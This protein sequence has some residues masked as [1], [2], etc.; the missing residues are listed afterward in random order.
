MKQDEKS[1]K[2][3]LHNMDNK[4]KGILEET[5]KIKK[6]FDFDK[7]G[8]IPAPCIHCPNHPSNGGTGICHCTLGT[9]KLY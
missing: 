9:A 7:I 4:Y 3:L 1:L 6:V 2:E 5:N 8:G